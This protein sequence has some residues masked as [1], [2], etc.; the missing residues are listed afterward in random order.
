M[1]GP[2]VCF[3]D[4]LGLLSALVVKA[5]HG[6]DSGEERE[7]KTR[8]QIKGGGEFVSA[9]SKLPRENSLQGRCCWR[10]CQQGAVHIHGRV[11]RGAGELEELE[12]ST[13]YCGGVNIQDLSSAEVERR[14]KPT[15]R[16]PGL[17]ACGSEQL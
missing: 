14:E 9:A 4:A 12:N 17:R 15:R 1:S 8:S 13:V 2:G 10:S 11:G 3:L 5:P 6:S 16:A 7:E